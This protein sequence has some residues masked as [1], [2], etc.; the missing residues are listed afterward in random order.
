MSLIVQKFGG[1]SVA[2]AAWGW[3]ALAFVALTFANLAH[4]FGYGGQVASL[5]NLLFLGTAVF[6]LVVAFFAWRGGSRAAGWFLIAWGLLADRAIG[7]AACSRIGL[8]FA[9]SSIGRSSSAS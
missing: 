4:L 3:L 8:T 1:S 7:E 6:T 9:A 5:G 2:D